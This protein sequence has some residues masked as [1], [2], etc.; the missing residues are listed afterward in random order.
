[1]FA[2]KSS[3]AKICKIPF[4][5]HQIAYNNYDK[6]YL[7]EF[8]NWCFYSPEALTILSYWSLSIIYEH[9]S[10]VYVGIFQWK[11]SSK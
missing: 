3:I 10:W 9:Q 6:S 7:I 1:M 2:D 11:S 8:Q 4:W 5:A